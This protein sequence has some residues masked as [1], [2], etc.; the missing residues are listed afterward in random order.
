MDKIN[1]I[2]E[3]HTNPEDWTSG[4]RAD[5]IDAMK[6]YANEY[7]LSHLRNKYNPSFCKACKYWTVIDS[8]GG[9]Y[10]RVLQK[11]VASPRDD[12]KHKDCP[13]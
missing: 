11:S 6:E 5:V 1:E 7:H 10:C 13:L 3:R 8:L 12:Y 9:E 2:L 4:F